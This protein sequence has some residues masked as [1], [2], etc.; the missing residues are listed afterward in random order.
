MAISIKEQIT[1]EVARLRMEQL[2][3]DPATLPRKTEKAHEQINK[4]L[5]L[6]DAETLERFNVTHSQ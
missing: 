3:G 6:L 2:D 4:L 1:R 5:D